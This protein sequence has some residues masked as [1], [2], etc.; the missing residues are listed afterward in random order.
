MQ[1][2]P[3]RHALLTAVAGFLKSDV[4]PAVK[5]PGVRFRLLVATHVL[6]VLDRELAGEH[7]AWAAQRDRLVALGLPVPSELLDEPARRAAIAGAHAALV[8]RIDGAAPG[9]GLAAERAH[10][11]AT[12]RE[13]LAVV[14]PR[15]DLSPTIE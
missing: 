14:N 12:L 1:D 7:G 15:F 11:L 3:D 2:R 8:A 13:K 6:G 4:M 10:I 5:D 9:D